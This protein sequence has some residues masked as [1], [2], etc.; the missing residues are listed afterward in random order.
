MVTTPDLECWDNKGFC[1]VWNLSMRQL[2]NLEVHT[3][4]K[5]QNNF[6]TINTLVNLTLKL[7]QKSKISHDTHNASQCATIFPLY[8][9]RPT[10]NKFVSETKKSSTDYKGYNWLINQSYYLQEQSCGLENDISSNVCP[11]SFF[12]RG[13][14]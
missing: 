4:K 9:L 7:Q 5:S 13:W 11:L 12:W 3:K 8:A 14:Q 10:L 1:S 6:V 2:P